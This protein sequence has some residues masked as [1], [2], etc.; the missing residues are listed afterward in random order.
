MNK[1]GHLED[2]RV[3][4]RLLQIEFLNKWTGN[5]WSKFFPLSIKTRGRLLKT[6]K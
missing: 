3:D 1:E 6:G 4:E 2:L 5:L